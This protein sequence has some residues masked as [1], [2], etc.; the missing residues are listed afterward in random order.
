MEGF[1][2]VLGEIHDDGGFVRVWM[3]QPQASMASASAR[4]Q[5]SGI[6]SVIGTVVVVGGTAGGGAA[7]AADGRTAGRA[8]RMPADHLDLAGFGLNN[9]RT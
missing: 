2:G 6:S 5:W 1:H 3:V 7:G 4:T 8:G 9:S